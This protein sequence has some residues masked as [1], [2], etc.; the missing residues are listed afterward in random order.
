MVDH[1]VDF[2]IIHQGIINAH[3]AMF[4]EGI[5]V[6]IIGTHIMSVTETFEE[7]VEDIGT[8]RD[9]HIDQ[10]H[11][12]HIGNHLAHSA[13]DHRSGEPQEDNALRILEHLPKDFE[14]FEDIPALKG[15]VL[16]GLNQIEKAPN[17]SEV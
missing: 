17:F 4:P 16:E 13:R 10:F 14:A 5:I 2:T 7:V 12:D 1:S 9:N 11:P 8:R 15:G 6:S 3:D